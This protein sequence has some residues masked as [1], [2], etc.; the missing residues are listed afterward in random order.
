MQHLSIGEAGAA[1]GDNKGWGQRNVRAI[2]SQLHCPG[3]TPVFRPTSHN[4]SIAAE[5]AY[6]VSLLADMK[7]LT[8]VQ[9][10]RKHD[11]LLAW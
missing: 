9:P 2:D 8:Q 11:K 1:M 3:T 5:L 6:S 4:Q 10:G 7:L